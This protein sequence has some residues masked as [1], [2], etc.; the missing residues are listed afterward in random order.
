MSLLAIDGGAS[1]AKWRLQDDNAEVLAE[2]RTLPLHGHLFSDGERNTAV[3]IITGLG[4]EMRGH[5]PISQ[6]LAGIT[7][8][9]SASDAAKW[10]QKQFCREFGL[11]AENVL[12]ADDL[13]LVCL[14]TLRPGR[15]MLIYA[16]T[17]SV[18]YY[19]TPDLR[20]LRAGGY[21][22]MIDDAGSGFWIGAQALKHW[23]RDV[24]TGTPGTGPLARALEAR[25]G[26]NRFND[27]RGVVYGGGRRTVAS[28]S[29]EVHSAANA[30]DPTAARILADAGAELAGLAGRL[31]QATGRHSLTVS[32]FGGIRACGPWVL[33]P[34]RKALAPGLDLV[35][36]EIEGAAAICRAVQVHGFARLTELV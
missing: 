8:L 34:M 29:K 22:F 2:G 5:G 12:V 31:F 7:G 26:S 6:V 13:W 14:G 21:G 10:F 20:P 35:D 32:M 30:G 15:D 25:F 19:L 28:L 3:E 11:D 16:G 23:M 18:G 27:V 1:A 36:A 9:G 33:D 24:E 17:G 4:A